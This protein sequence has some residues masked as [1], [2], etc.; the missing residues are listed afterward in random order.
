MIN[1]FSP[2][3][4]FFKKTFVFFIS[5]IIVFSLIATPKPA[6]AQVFTSDIGVLMQNIKDFMWLNNRN[7]NKS[8]TFAAFLLR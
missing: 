7:S 1:K 4:N 2:K 6:H 3:K 8:G 5:L